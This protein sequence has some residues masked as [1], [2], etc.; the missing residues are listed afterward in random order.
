MLDSF[1]V[2]ASTQKQFE[3]AFSDWF[4]CTNTPAARAA[5][6]KLQ[7]A[8]GLLGAVPPTRYQITE[9]YLPQLYDEC[10]ERVLVRLKAA[11]SFMVAMD[12]W[13]KQCAGRGSPLIN[14]LLLL[15]HGGTCFWDVINAAG[16]SKNA[17]YIKQ[18]CEEVMQELRTACG[19]KVLGFVM[20]S[21]SA[22]RA[23][24]TE[25]VKAHPELIN[26]PCIS[27]A[28]SLLLKDLAKHFSWVA[29]VYAA[30]VT[31]SNAQATES[32]K[33][34][35]HQSMLAQPSKTIFSI[36]THCDTRFGS[37]HIV[38]RTVMR[39]LQPLKEM[40]AKDAFVQL[41]RGASSE[42]AKKLHAVVT[43]I[44]DDGL[45]ALGGTLLNLGNSIMDAI[46]QLEADRPLLS[47][48]LPMIWQLEQV[49]ADF[50]SNHPDL[51]E[52]R[53]KKKNTPGPGTRISMQQVF[54]RRL[55]EFLFRDCFVAAYVLDPV[56]FEFDADAGVW[57][58]PNANLS[59][60]EEDAVRRDLQRMGGSKAESEWDDLVLR[61]LPATTG[62]TNAFIKCAARTED[63]KG[64]VL[65]A[66]IQLRKNVWNNFLRKEKN[67]AGQSVSLYPTLADLAITYMSVHATACAPERN[68]SRWGNLYAKNRNALEIQKGK[69]MIF[70][71]ENDG[72]GGQARVEDEELLF[73]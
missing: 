28:L 4:L 45:P 44:Q 58:V 53:K 13:K 72:D 33:H 71:Q 54:D 64:R 20:D 68:W 2:A 25:L 6:T 24:L 17:E 26:L 50:Q 12:G 73:S 62:A 27:H 23:A 9:V 15:P 7:R 35:L 32:I 11:K 10:R 40:A 21:A 18:C 46:H 61:N 31:V 41:T 22:N 1:V 34:M 30:A 59:D 47:R 29:E 43:N 19:A 39:A 57:R 16:R 51:S 67:A 5:S 14:I 36:A 37:H 56:N 38:L 63:D 65:V 48:V 70:L 66:D 52:G 49:A 3:K 8:C 55:R 69:K 42:N 60:D